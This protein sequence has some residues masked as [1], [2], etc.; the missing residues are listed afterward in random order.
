MPDATTSPAVPAPILAPPTAHQ[1]REE[2]QELVL[3]DLL[4]PAGGPEEEVAEGRLKERYLVEPLM[5]P[6]Q[7]EVT[8]HRAEIKL[9]PD[10][11]EEAQAKSPAGRR[12]AVGKERRCRTAGGREPSGRRRLRAISSRPS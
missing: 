12:A 1:L 2:L 11:G 6:R 10:C 3:R 7:L 5:P 9:R 8:E 4:G